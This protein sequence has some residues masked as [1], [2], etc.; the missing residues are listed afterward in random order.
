MKII[1]NFQIRYLNEITSVDKNYDVTIDPLNQAKF[2]KE[3]KY[4]DME[5]RVT[6]E[7]LQK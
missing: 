3:L 6:I 4:Y 5:Y 1:L 2:E 7:D